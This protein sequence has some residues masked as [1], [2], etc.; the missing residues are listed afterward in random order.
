MDLL[1]SGKFQS[2]DNVLNSFP[3][4]KKLKDLNEQSQQKA[5]YVR[6]KAMINKSHAQKS[7][8]RCQQT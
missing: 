8:N 5:Q 1:I 4:D 2:Q 7:L 6:L 3:K